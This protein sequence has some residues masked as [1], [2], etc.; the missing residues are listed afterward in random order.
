MSESEDLT[1]TLVYVTMLFFAFVMLYNAYLYLAERVVMIEEPVFVVKEGFDA[2]AFKAASGPEINQG[3]RAKNDSISKTK[4]KAKAKAEEDKKKGITTPAEKEALDR[5]NPG[6]GGG[7]DSPGPGGSGMGPSGSGTGP[8]GNSMGP[9][10]SGMGPS[11]SGMG[12]SGSG[13]GPSGGGTG[14]SGGGTGPGGGEGFQG[15]QNCL[16]VAECQTMQTANDNAKMLSKLSQKVDQLSQ[17]VSN[18]QAAQVSSAKSKSMEG[19][20]KATNSIPNSGLTKGV[21]SQA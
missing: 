11:G 5:S 6:G 9:S 18:M 12:P 3:L 13:T 17:N 7:D 20:K 8:S 14:P 4:K 1:K 21:K 15:N 10:G 19:A 16:S 2:A